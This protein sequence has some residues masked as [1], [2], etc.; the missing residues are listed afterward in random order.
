LLL[1]EGGL[2]NFQAEVMCNEFS[3]VHYGNNACIGKPHLLAG[4]GGISL[5][6][7]IFISYIVTNRSKT[8]HR[9]ECSIPPAVRFCCRVIFK[10]SVVR[11]E[12]PRLSKGL[13]RT[14]NTLNVN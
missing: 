8:G 12:S 6:Y 4:Q 10:L 5:D 9:P 11:Q 7:K 13:T 3:A 1:A 14:D 2:V